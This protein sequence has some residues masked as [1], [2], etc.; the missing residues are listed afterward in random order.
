MITIAECYYILGE[1]YKEKDVFKAYGFYEEAAR[2]GSGKAAM[3]LAKYF[4]KLKNHEKAFVW[5]Q[6]VLEIDCEESAEAAYWVGEYYEYGYGPVQANC[7]EAYQ[8][9]ERAAD[10]G[11]EAAKKKLPYKNLKSLKN[12]LKEMF[13]G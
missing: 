11:F 13:V 1:Y 2:H 7:Q 8:Y 5:F 6:K 9:Y 4:K 10:V 3:L 12:I